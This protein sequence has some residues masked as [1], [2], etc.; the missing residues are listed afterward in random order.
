MAED[1]ELRD[2]LRGEMQVVD[3]KEL[4]P[5]QRRD[6][7]LIVRRDVDILEVALAIAH[8]KALEVAGLIE[9]KKV[10]KPTMGELADWCVDL[11]LRLQFVILQPYVLAQ[12]LD[13]SPIA[14]S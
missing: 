4:L 6:A 11:D 10:Y 7:L 2:K 5:H 8:D 13:R 9:E 12:V 1:S 14:Q 3:A